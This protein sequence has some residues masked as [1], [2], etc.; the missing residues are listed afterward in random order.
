M[1]KYGGDHLNSTGFGLSPSI[2]D[3]IGMGNDTNMHYNQQIERRDDPNSTSSYNNYDR[4]GGI[5]DHIQ[6][7]DKKDATSGGFLS[8]DGK[9]ADAT[10]K[11]PI[12][13]TFANN[14]TGDSNNLK[15]IPI[16]K[17]P[18][19]IPHG[20]GKFKTIFKQSSVS[21]LMRH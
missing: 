17:S 7:F 18:D 11:P 2:G 4:L 6:G 13:R 5:Y 14:S 9:P 15:Q 19:V 16:D 1:D 8:Q 12:V 21:Q 10:N 20:I 3:N